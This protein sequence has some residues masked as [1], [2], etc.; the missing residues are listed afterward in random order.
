MKS[1]DENNTQG[2]HQNKNQRIKLVF[3]SKIGPQGNFNPSF[4]FA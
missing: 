2:G 3:S 4:E 1:Q